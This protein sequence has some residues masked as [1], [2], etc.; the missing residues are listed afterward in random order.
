MKKNKPNKFYLILMIVFWLILTESIDMQMVLTGIGICF[1]VFYINMDILEINFGYSF[2]NKKKLLYLFQYLLL[3]CKEI[4]FANFHVAKIVLSRKLLITPSIISFDTRLEKP[5]SRTI[6][7]NSITLT[8]GTLTVKM[9]GKRLIVHC[10][11]DEYVEGA[12]HSKFEEL[13]LKVE[14]KPDDD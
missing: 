3:L 6:L 7:A 5:L 12:M 4:V 11:M 2:K 9:D 13:L 14:E 1:L 10:L 8:P